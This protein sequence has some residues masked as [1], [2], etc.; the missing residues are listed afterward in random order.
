MDYIFFIATVLVVFAKI[1]VIIMPETIIRNLSQEPQNPDA[2]GLS[3]NSEALGPSGP[4]ITLK[5]IHIDD[6]DLPLK[7]Q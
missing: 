6:P 4:I 2:R 3:P 5:C 7:C 1:R